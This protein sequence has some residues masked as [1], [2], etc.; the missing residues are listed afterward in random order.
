MS[1]EKA[2]A[3]SRPRQSDLRRRSST[4]S[5]AAIALRHLL[6]LRA[7]VKPLLSHS[8]TGEFG[9]FQQ[10][11]EILTPIIIRGHF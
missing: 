6:G 11:I 8:T 9:K 4:R 10:K 1:V 3:S 5:H 7:A 2:G